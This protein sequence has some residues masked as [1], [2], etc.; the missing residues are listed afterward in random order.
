[1]W[2]QSRNYHFPQKKQCFDIN[3]GAQVTWDATVP[4]AQ[5]GPLIPGKARR[6]RMKQIPLHEL[7][8][9]KRKT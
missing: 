1:M 7:K 5:S 2:F 9:I 3:P 4:L 8:A 6:E